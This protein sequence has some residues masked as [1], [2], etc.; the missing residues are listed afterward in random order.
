MKS[1]KAH[2]NTCGGNRNHAVLHSET[3]SW[4]EDDAGISGGNRY[5]MIKCLGCEAIRM[6]DESWFSEHE[7]TTTRQFSGSSRD[8]FRT[9]PQCYRTANYSLN[10]C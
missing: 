9:Y 8:G 1:T 7:G 6:R 5:E 10:P 2:C 3:T 4:R